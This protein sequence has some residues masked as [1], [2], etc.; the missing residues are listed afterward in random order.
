[1]RL[2]IS[3]TNRVYELEW[4]PS[5]MQLRN[6]LRDAGFFFDE[7]NIELYGVFDNGAS[8]KGIRRLMTAIKVYEM[9]LGA[10]ATEPN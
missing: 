1:M 8:E 3:L 2:Y 4:L 7:D 6:D 10:K 9:K 5:R